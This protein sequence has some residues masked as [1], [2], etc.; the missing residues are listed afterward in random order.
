[1]ESLVVIE[2]QMCVSEYTFKLLGFVRFFKCFYF[3]ILAQ[4][5]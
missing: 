5:F 3:F 4:G 2:K 1:M